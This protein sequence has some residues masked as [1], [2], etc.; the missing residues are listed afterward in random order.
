M[1][2][3]GTAELS[4]GRSPISVNLGKVFRPNSHKIVILSAALHRWIACHSAYR[5][6]VEGPRR[7]FSAHAFRSFSTT[8]AREQDPPWY[9]PWSRVHPCMRCD[10]FHRP[11]CVKSLTRDDLRMSLCF[12]SR[13]QRWRCF[14]LRALQRNS[15]METRRYRDGLRWLKSSEK[16]GQKSSVGVLRLRATKRCGTRSICEALRS[17]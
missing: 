7:C 8:E 5:R 2:P 1:T 11:V 12:L 13:H 4:P 9:A 3:A 10:I 16:H 15:Q 6:G 14:S 17:G